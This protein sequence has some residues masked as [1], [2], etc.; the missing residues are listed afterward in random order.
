M[1][2]PMNM[3]PILGLFRT[4][5][6]LLVT[7]RVDVL[8]LTL[9]KPVG[10]MLLRLLLVHVIMLRASTISL[11]L[12]LT[13]FIL[14]DNPMQPRFPLPVPILSGLAVVTLISVLRLGRWKLVP[15]LRAIPL[16]RVR[17]RL[18]G[19]PISGPILISAV[20]LPMNMLYS[21]MS[22][23]VIR[24]VM[25]VGNPVRVMTLV[26]PVVLMFLTGLTVIPVSVLGP[27]I[28]ILLTLML[29]LISVTVRKPWP[30]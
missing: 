28:V 27:E 16:L 18:L 8:L 2:M 23:L 21:P 19:A 11:V 1:K 6:N 9:K 14:L 22:I 7:I 15:L 17:T 26:V 25:L 5:L 3:S 24:L 30:V 20:L 13:T 10:P 4:T 29:F 12:P